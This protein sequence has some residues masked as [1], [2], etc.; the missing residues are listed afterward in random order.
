MLS[1]KNLKASIKD[2][3]IYLRGLLNFINQ[4]AIAGMRKSLVLSGVGLSSCLLVT[5]WASEARSFKLR[6]SEIKA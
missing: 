5:V 1:K 2:L 4:E 6:N 3:M